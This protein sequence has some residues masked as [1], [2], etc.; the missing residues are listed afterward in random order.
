M[1][2]IFSEGFAHEVSPSMI[3]TVL[4][5]SLIVPVAF[6]V[7]RSIGLYKLAKRKNFKF[8][9]IAFIPCVWIYVACRL[10]AESKFFG[11]TIGKLAIVF[12]IVFAVA[13]LLT[14]TYQFL[15]YFPLVGNYFMGREIFIST[16]VE[17]AASQGFKPFWTDDN[18]IWISESFVYPYKDIYKMVKIINGLYYVSMIFDLAYM[19]IELT[20][21]YNLFRKYWPQRHVLAFVMS[22][23]LGLSGPFIFAIRNK[24]PINYIDY[25]RSRYNSYGPYGPYYGP[26][27]PYNNNGYGQNG[28]Q[29]NQQYQ[30]TPPK[31][32]FDEY[33][34]KSE[35]VPDEPFGQYNQKDKDGE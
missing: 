19:V 29:Y 34:D 1:I 11:T 5:V 23:F 13:E 30:Q 27:G 20:V 31:G 35:R 25:L 4:I 15:L 14:L 2:T 33:A 24:Q 16:D 8:A 9:I 10:V 28:S 7:L 32:P 26:R 17:Y 12:T 18:Q 21:L 3:L 22:V 6:Y